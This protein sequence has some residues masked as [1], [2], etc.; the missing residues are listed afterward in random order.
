MPTAQQETARDLFRRLAAL[1]PL[2]VPEHEPGVTFRDWPPEGAEVSAGAAGPSATDTTKYVPVLSVYLDMR[3]L[4]DGARPAERP[5][6]VTLRERL[7]QIEATFAP[8]GVAFDAVRDGAGQIE[9]Y[10]DTQVPPSTTGLAIFAS[11]PHQLF[12]AL[13][14]DVPLETQVVA[15]ALPDL[16]QLA[17]ALA[18]QEVT[19]VAVVEVNAARLFLLHQGGLRELRK[20]A[21]DPKYFHM[22][23][24]ANAM[25]QAHFQR[26]AVRTREKFATEVARQIDQLVAREHASRVILAGEVEALPLVR[27]ALSPEAAKLVG[28]LPRSLGETEFTAP[29]EIILEEIKPLLQAAKADQERTVVERL[30]VAVQSDKL[31]V[32]GLEPT[33]RALSYG[34][35]DTLILLADVTKSPGMSVDTRTELIDLATKTDADINIV[36]TSPQ[37]QQLG[38]VGALLRY[39][40]EPEPEPE[41]EP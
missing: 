33:R 31:G 35:V 17:R 1:E 2:P 36:D 23:H 6:R 15:A 40:I 20:M 25:N 12:E 19:V 13:V 9:R 22:V 34:Q 39:R 26:H 30:V 11:R 32:A 16:F 4:I 18:D 10:L 21:D 38:G 14:I 24:G 3:P 29:A 5:G 41:P 37:L 8:R 27:E 7:H 28:E